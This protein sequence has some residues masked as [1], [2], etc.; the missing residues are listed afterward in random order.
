MSTDPEVTSYARLASSL[1]QSIN[2][3]GTEVGFNL[4]FCLVYCRWKAEDVAEHGDGESLWASFTNRLQA[5]PMQADLRN[6]RVHQPPDAAQA[7]GEANN[8]DKLIGE[9]LRGPSLSELLAELLPADAED[10]YLSL[11]PSDLTDQTLLPI[12]DELRLPS[13]YGIGPGRMRK[14]MSLLF[15]ALLNLRATEVSPSAVVNETPRDV[16]ELMAGLVCSESD[17]VLDLASGFGG[18]LKASSSYLPFHL[19]G[20]EIDAWSVLM[21]RMRLE[22]AGINATIEYGD[23]LADVMRAGG[24]PARAVASAVLAHP[25]G[26]RKRSSGD[27]SLD[28]SLVLGASSYFEWVHAAL[29]G[30]LPGGRAAVILPGESLGPGGDGNSKFRAQLLERGLVEAVVA[31]PARAFGS[32]S[33]PSALWI[34]RS[35]EADWHTG[36]V[37]LVDGSGYAGGDQVRGGIEHGTDA[38]SEH[39]ALVINRIKDVVLEFRHT[40]ETKKAD[41]NG[42]LSVSVATDLLAT[43]DE[44]AAEAF[45]LAAAG[46]D[47]TPRRRARG[48]LEMKLKELRVSNFKAFGREQSAELAP[49]TLIYGP[50]SAGKSSLIEALLL[51]K[52]SVDQSPSLV[53]DGPDVN[54]GSFVGALHRHDI[55]SVLSIGA[56]YGPSFDEGAFGL[57]FSFQAGPSREGRQTELAIHFEGRGSE[58]GSVRLTRAEGASAGLD[59]EPAFMITSSDARV[60]LD[61]FG[62]AYSP[63]ASDLSAVQLP[64]IES[65]ENSLSEADIFPIKWPVAGLTPNHLKSPPLIR[66]ADNPM[67]FLDSVGYVPYGLKICLQRTSHLGPLRDPLRERVYPRGDSYPGVG[68]IEPFLVGSLF[69]NKSL[70]KEVNAWFVKLGIPYEMEVVLVEASGDRPWLLPDL[71]AICLTDTRSGVEVTPADVGFGVGQLLPIVA[72]LLSQVDGITCIQQPEIHVHPRL[73]TGIADLFIHATQAEGFSG[74]VIAETHSEAIILR[75]QRRIREGEIDAAS[76]SVL[77]VDQDEEGT[78]SITRL[79]LDD[80]GDFIDRWPDGF[81]VEQFDELL[82]GG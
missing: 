77:Y 25:P 76:V 12:V 24:V 5:G 71:L 72:Q 29:D 67:R 20:V 31:L 15:E 40:G 43:K 28:D 6:R 58:S 32:A 19:R 61:V 1:S 51:L 7:L 69:N 48:N 4:L 63:Q 79:R 73:Q 8:T 37:L 82:G 53:T 70:V 50:N 46:G 64:S 42:L 52:Q 59:S 68:S 2:R 33:G 34:L 55:Q 13:A 75:L 22:L 36:P 26:T 3:L 47:G 21:S 44:F 39:N 81:F 65:I 30:L 57:D 41:P 9:L 60:L 78:A 56:S 27:L 66:G 35:E 14:V 38:A 74:Q 18:T 54:V 11:L 10:W 23:G 17:D 45:L 80:S 16:S 62:P 49:I